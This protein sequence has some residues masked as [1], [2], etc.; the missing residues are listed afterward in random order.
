MTGSLTFTGAT[1]L[2]LDV[3][4]N[5]SPLQKKPFEPPL[6]ANVPIAAGHEQGKGS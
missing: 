2:P 3:M 6:V 5:V 1:K 4:V